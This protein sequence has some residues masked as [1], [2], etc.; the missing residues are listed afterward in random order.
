MPLNRHDC[1]RSA[2]SRSANHGFSKGDRTQAVLCHRFSKG[3]YWAPG[4]G[5]GNCRVDQ[6]SARAA[7]QTIPPSINYK[8]P[9]PRIDFAS[10]P[11]YVNTTLRDFPPADAPRR[12]G[13]NSL[14]IGGTNTF[15]VL[16][17]APPT[18][19]I[20]DQS[21]RF[22]RLITLS[23]KS[24]DALVARVEQFLYWLNDNPDAPIGDLC[25]TT[26]VSRSQFL[27][28]YAAPA[29]SVAEL[30]RHLAAW[31]QSVAE[32][33]STLQSTSSAPI[34]FM[35]SGQGSQHAG[36]AAQLYRSH[37]I[38]RNAMDRCHALAKPYL[39]QGLLDVIFAQKQR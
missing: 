17:E 24:A 30:K 13:L 34:A 19:A 38:I 1:R 22:P 39:E 14:G 21:D 15:A 27:F 37:S 32:N 12:A 36:M 33:A 6:N 20:T 2:R 11:F 25:Y 4:A 10:S 23:A 31:L 9:N 28:R 18:V 3:Q 16:E 35:F 29:R 26:N 8:T 7:S 5:G